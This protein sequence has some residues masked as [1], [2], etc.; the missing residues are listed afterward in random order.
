MTDPTTLQAVVNLSPI[1]AS[2]VEFDLNNPDSEGYD[3]SYEG[4][5]S[6]NI[7]QDL[8]IYDVEQDLYIDSNSEEQFSGTI[9]NITY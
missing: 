4:N 9:G 3:P 6:D 1:S 5:P 8:P 7:N 2:V